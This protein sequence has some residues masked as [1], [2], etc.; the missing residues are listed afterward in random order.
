MKLKWVA[1]M[2]IVLTVFTMSIS[3][4][5]ESAPAD[6]FQ[7]ANE[8]YQSGNFAQA[9]DLYEQILQQ[10]LGSFALYYD[11]GNAYYRLGQLGKSRLWFERAQRLD[12][13]DEDVRYNLKL[14]RSQIQDDAESPLRLLET[15]AGLLGWVFL[16]ANLFFFAVLAAGLFSRSEW[17]WWGRWIAGLFFLCALGLF[18]LAKT[19]GRT[20]AA[21]V[22]EPRV[23]VRAGPGED[24]RVGFVVPEGQ[25]VVVF[26][27]ASS[28]WRE[29]G[30]PARGL[31]GW[32]RREA[33]EPISLPTGE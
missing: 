5:A 9:K 31:K 33:V 3:L 15:S 17:I 14:I 6:V 24:F 16:A 19:Q 12:P 27:D 8:A 20:P 23:E 11:L 7:K 2:T 30:V 13:G 4:R 22:L 29:I 25:K 28:G 32:A 1:G 21:I 18:V 26:Q 10:G